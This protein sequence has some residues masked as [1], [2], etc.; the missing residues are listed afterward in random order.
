MT[1]RN[2]DHERNQANDVHEHSTR[3]TF[4]LLM[5]YLVIIVGIWGTIYLTL[6]SRG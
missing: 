3:G 4:V 1:G 2:A 6:L 5:V